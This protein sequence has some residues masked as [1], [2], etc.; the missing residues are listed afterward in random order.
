MISDTLPG[1]VAIRERAHHGSEPLGDAPPGRM[2]AHR[3]WLSLTLLVFA[4]PVLAGALPGEEPKLARPT[5]GQLEWQR[6]ELEMFI[7]FGPATWEN[8]QHSDL[9][10]PLAAINPEQLNTEQWVDVAVS[11]GAGIIIFVAKHDGGFCWWPTVTTDYSVRSTPWRNGTGDLMRE[12]SDS[13]RRRGLKLGVYLSPMDKMNGAQVGGRTVN[14]AD[15]DRYTATYRQQLTELL[16]RYGEIA[17]VWFDGGLVVPVSDILQLHAPG[18]MVFQGP[19]ATIRWVGNEEGVAPYP[20]WNAL[21][22][23]KARSGIAT[24]YDS[25]PDGAAWLPSEC[26]AR[27]RADWFWS[28]GNASTLK[29]VESLMRMYYHS[30]GHGAV[31]LLNQTPDRTGQIPEADVLRTAEFGAEI[32]RRFGR[33]L[34]ETGGHGNLFELSLPRPEWVDH[35]IAAEDISQ[36]ERVREYVVEGWTGGGWRRICEGTAIGN[37]KIDFFAPV[38]VSKV[39]LRVVRAAATPQFRRV[40][41]FRAF[42]ET[43]PAAAR[44][45]LEARPLTLG[46]WSSETLGLEQTTLRLDLS[47]ACRDA[48]VYLLELA[49]T[50]GAPLDIEKV[51][52]I[53]DGLSL[54]PFV[55]RREVRGVP[56]YQITITTEG[57]RH[58]LEVRARLRSTD[59]RGQFLIR[60]RLK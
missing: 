20:T 44:E 16:S 48:G 37:K 51:D 35:L 21:P 8:V 1:A 40:A 32:R 43:M 12:L 18:A 14:A 10:A 58:E 39:R 36:G 29:S 19:H 31:L 4:T 9:S 41:V 54:S 22:M 26:D 5:P 56:Y 53:A 28:R 13:C 57:R 55:V 11:M 59:S 38:L 7:H 17:E 60:R 49:R 50:A 6:R 2:N 15:Q 30:V 27:L 25:D 24:A 45:E 23:V 46:N 42:G 33:S 52:L 3:R 34:A 47:R